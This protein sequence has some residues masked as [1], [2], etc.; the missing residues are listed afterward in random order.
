MI[1][2]RHESFMLGG[3]MF[4]LADHAENTGCDIKEAGIEAFAVLAAA[5]MGNGVSY[6]DLLKAIDIQLQSSQGAPRGLQ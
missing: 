2:T 4:M 1:T 6:A 5:L 3:L